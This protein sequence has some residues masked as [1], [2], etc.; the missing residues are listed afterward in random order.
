M[1]NWTTSSVQMTGIANE[2]G[3]FSEVD[4]KKCFDFNKIIPEP[5]TE[6]EY[7]ATG[8]SLY[9]CP[10]DA[11]LQ[12][13]KDKPWFNWYDWH[14]DHWG[15][16]WNACDTEIDGDDCIRFDT[17]WS[18]PRPIFLALSKMY[19]D[20]FIRVFT[21]YEGEDDEYETVYLNGEVLAESTVC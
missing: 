18:S 9:R 4:G 8:G 21:V 17:A 2:N 11:Y 15:T 7:L 13:D 6:K 20:R 16:K 1:P 12:I 10:E 14:C 19:P 3:L 5:S